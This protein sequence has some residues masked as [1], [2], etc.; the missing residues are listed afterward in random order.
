MNGHV[1]LHCA[2]PG[3]A[4]MITVLARH[5]DKIGEGWLCPVCV[6]KARTDAMLEQLDD[7]ERADEAFRAKQNYK[8]GDDY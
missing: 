8:T 6:D 1:S 4:S 3:C 7:M 5:F 2:G